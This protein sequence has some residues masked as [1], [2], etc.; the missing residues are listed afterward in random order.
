MG[1]LLTMTTGALMDI[2]LEYNNLASFPD[3]K[4]VN[5]SIVTFGVQLKMKK[6]KKTCISISTKLLMVRLYRAL[7]S[8]YGESLCI[9]LT[10]P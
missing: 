3:S 6:E 4:I 5:F 9:T 10:V 1:L 8:L 7:S 2:I